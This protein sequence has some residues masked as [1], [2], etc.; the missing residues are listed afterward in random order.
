[1]FAPGI[2][3]FAPGI[4]VFAPENTGVDKEMSFLKKSAWAVVLLA[5]D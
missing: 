4:R 3:M 1:M 2:R 5:A